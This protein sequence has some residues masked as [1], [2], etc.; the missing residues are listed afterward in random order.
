MKKFLSLIL[1]LAMVLSMTACGGDGASDEGGE[2]GTV[3]LTLAHIRPVGSS[4]DEAINAFAEEV[5]EL[6]NGT[7]QFEIY[8]AAQLGDYPVVQERVA[9]GDV[10]MQIA[11]MGTTMDKGFSLSNAP[12]LVTN[13]EEAQEVFSPGGVVAEA[14]SDL[15]A[16]Y[17][18]TYL[19][20]YPLYFGGICLSVD[21]V[22]PTN[23]NAKSGIKIRV[24]SMAMFDAVAT[25]LGYLST[26]L[27]SSDL[28][29]SMQTGVVNGAI[30]MGAEGYYSNMADLVKY[31]L[32]INDHFE[33]WYLYIN[34]EKF[35]SLTAEQQEAIQTAAIH[36]Q[37]A[38]WEVA[39]AETADYEQK[40]AD[41]GTIVVEYTDEQLAEFAEVVRE[42]AWPVVEE[43][44]GTEVWSQVEAALAG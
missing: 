33:Q 24:P 31:Y 13:W 29:T 4:A 22:D 15:L 14:T 37:D 44:V 1:A 12:Y 25:A 41:G 9:I 39:E 32:P 7:V 40:L 28:F 3:T 19:C 18:M 42:A 35:E 27:A 17:G 16:K 11:P 34:T 6:T 30:G 26:P 8:P 23:P 21:A 38:R 43:E 2:G 20:S 5:G 36:M 10:D